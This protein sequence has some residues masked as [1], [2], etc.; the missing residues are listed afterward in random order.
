MEDT[1]TDGC[2]FVKLTV[3]HSSRLKLECLAFSYK[4]GHSN[5]SN[6]LKWTQKLH[7][8]KTQM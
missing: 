8:Q 3:T 6:K 4:F 1:A 5:I 7:T 2:T